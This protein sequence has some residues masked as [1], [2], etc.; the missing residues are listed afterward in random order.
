VVKVEDDLTMYYGGVAA[1]LR[2]PDG[3]LVAA[4]DP[5]RD[6]AVR[7]VHGSAR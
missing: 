5:R 4:A 2:R 1:T 6:G 7:L 3:R